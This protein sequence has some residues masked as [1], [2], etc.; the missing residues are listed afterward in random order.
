MAI[1]FDL[2][3]ITA[4]IFGYEAL[5]FP[6]L[7]LKNPLPDVSNIGASIIGANH[8]GVPY[9]MDLM[10]DNLIFPNEPLM[11]FSKQK[12]IVETPVQGA[13]GT[14]KELI[15]SSDYRIKIQGICFDPEKKEYPRQQVEDIKA[16]F[17]ENRA[18][19]VSNRLCALF[20][21]QKIVLKNIDWGKMQGQPFSQ[22]FSIDAV[23]DRDFYATL[24][25]SL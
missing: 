21:I 19:T 2:Q 22:S 5:P 8:L 14:V 20:G 1:E 7:G 6:L 25:F 9:F 4:D 16:L 24:K 17:D 3:K 18:L 10:V 12:V 13:E 11:T 15:S 23:S